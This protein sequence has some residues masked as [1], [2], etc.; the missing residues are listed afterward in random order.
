MSQKYT[1]IGRTVRRQ[2]IA[3]RLLAEARA[4]PEGAPIR[5]KAFL[6]LGSRAAVDQALSRLTKAGKLLRLTRGLYVLPVES[7]FGAR[8]PEAEKVIRSLAA[9]GR[10]TIER[11]GAAE[12]NGLGLTQQV[13]V[14]AVYWTSGRSR[15]L[16]FGHQVVHLQRVE[17]WKLAL[18]DRP[19]GAALRALATV[20][21]EEIPQALK[22]I[23]RKLPPREIE[24]LLGSRGI[25][26]GWLAEKVS[27]LARS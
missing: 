14:R 6:H 22:T 16:H 9:E 10:E 19:A 12:A 15:D 13:P 26:P 7:R 8:P 25:L 24:C 18:R 21:R 2:A 4:L 5:A 23:R 11:G 17:H 27:S 3:E 20:G 1:K